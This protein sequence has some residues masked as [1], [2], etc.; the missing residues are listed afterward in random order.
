M[1]FTPDNG[2]SSAGDTIEMF[3][4]LANDNDADSEINYINV[5]NGSMFQHATTTD[6]DL[7]PREI[8][9]ANVFGM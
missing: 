1:N 2:M 3:R 5:E 4:K 6:D 8:T 9:V 7:P